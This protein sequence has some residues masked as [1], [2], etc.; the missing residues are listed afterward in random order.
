MEPIPAR[1]ASEVRF[2]ETLDVVVVGLG[3]AGASA[4]VAARQ[5]G[6]EV[7]AVERGGGPGGTSA[8]S[9]GLV[10][11]GGGTALQG[12]CGFTDSPENMATFLRAA[13]GPGADD[14][15]I[16]A[17]C[18]GSPEHF[19]W[20]VSV[21]VPFRA[22][23]C[24]EPNR[25]SAD[26]A[27][28]L[29]SGGEDSYPFD[30]LAVPVPRGHK[31]QYV[32][33]AGGFLME[34]LGAAVSAS[35][36]RVVADA[37]AEALVVDGGEVVGVEVRTDDR[38]R[39]FR[40]RGGVILATG[41]FIHNE[42][43]VAEH[44]PLA[45][46]PDAA[47]RIGTPA[48]D[49]RGIRMGAGAGAVTTR[50]DAFECALPLGPPHRL[51]RGIL[52]NGGGERFVNE[53][54]YTGRIGLQALRDHEGV[55]YMIT[56]DVIHEPNLLGLRIRHAA[57]TPEEL[58][59]DIEVPADALARTVGAYNEAAAHGE[60]PAFHKRAPYLQPIGVPPASGIGAID[61]RVDHGAIYAT[62]TLG[63]LVT[64]P[65][66]AALDVGGRRVPGLYAV[67]RT[68]ASLAA[69]D[70]ASGIS[71]GDGSFFGRRSGRHAAHRARAERSS[72]Q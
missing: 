15:R 62:F 65:E 60:D 31:P 38:S 14:D 19:D 55:V 24:D 71:L 66:G 8:Q 41:G 34:R 57:A 68:A 52:V 29:F 22:A 12:A 39:A 27:G 33:S 3:V 1:D 21:G 42:A 23:F 9:G 44:C 30:E 64:D 17:Y 7:L 56:D 36:A 5:A 53:D 45:H 63:G 43:M 10:Y 47:W 48:D 26:D 35:A 59:A 54:T 69:H 51:A 6:A 25:E 58:A 28:L 32:D 2:D 49:G 37:R 50:L 72:P 70:Y 16:D 40:A 20:L 4:A 61:L 18:E 67:G 13:L 46:V 11:L